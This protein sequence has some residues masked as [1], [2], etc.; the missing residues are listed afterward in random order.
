[1]KTRIP[2]ILAGLGFLYGVILLK[3]GDL[4]AYARPLAQSSYDPEPDNNWI[5]MSVPIAVGGP[6]SPATYTGLTLTLSDRDYFKIVYSGGEVYSITVSAPDGSSLRIGVSLRDFNDNQLFICEESGVRNLPCWSSGSRVQLR[7]FQPSS[8]I[9]YLRVENISPS[10]TDTYTLT[11]QTIGA[12]TPTPTL[13][14]TPTGTPP[15]TSTPTPLPTATPAGTPDAFEPNYDFEH[16]TLIGLGA[17]YT[18]LNFVPVVPGTEDNDFF[19]LWVKPGMVVTCETLDLTPG[20]DTNMI[21]YDAN[22]NGIAGNDDVDPRAGELRSRVTV[23]VT[24]EGWMYV[25]V[26]QGGRGIVYG[27]GYSLQCNVGLPPTPTPTPTRTPRPIT[28]VPPPPTATPF[29]TLPPTP[30][31]TPTPLRL[32]V[33]PLAATPTPAGRRIEVTVRIY[34]DANGNGAPDAGE[35]VIGMPVGLIALRGGRWIAQAATDEEGQASLV[36]FAEGTVRLVVPYLGIVR[37]VESGETVL[38]RLNPVP[39]PDRLP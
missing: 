2:L 32:Q 37:P 18:S 19:K 34:Y 27:S 36:G 9:M 8:T 12:A 7:W 22:R 35:G 21:I 33:Q 13:T 15:P 39:L 25:L 26:G 28:E 17:K 1:M 4:P 20:T 29:P 5:T 31:A 11:A 24:W 3:F 23:G 14:P 38:I 30:P 6:S 10:A 16:A